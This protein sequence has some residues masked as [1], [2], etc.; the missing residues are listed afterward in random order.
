[1]RFKYYLLATVTG[2]TFLGGQ[3]VPVFAQEG[4]TSNSTPKQVTLA[5]HVDNTPTVSRER[6]ATSKLSATDALFERVVNEGIIEEVRLSP[7]ELLFTPKD[8][9]QRALK[10]GLSQVR[11]K[12][13][14]FGSNCNKFSRYFGKGCQAWCADFVSWAFDST[15]NRDKRVAWR[16]PS[17]VASILQWAKRTKNVVKTPKP[18]DIFLIRKNGVSHTGLIR[19]VG[20]RT[21]TTIEGNASNRVRSVKRSLSKGYVFV[22]VPS[23]Q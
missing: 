17:A 10:Q 13:Q 12:E 1:M 3:V 15:G 19:S 5:P 2:L 16:N 7:Q 22:R 11:Y 23:R 20:R 14:P 8:F 4:D 6:A 18:G 21:F 9:R